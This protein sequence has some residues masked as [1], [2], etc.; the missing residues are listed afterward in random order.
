MAD[1]QEGVCAICGGINKDGRRLF[2]DHDHSTGKVRGLLCT[3]CNFGVGHFNDDVIL[4][5]KTVGYI[6][7][8]K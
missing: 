2:I 8:G 5:L 6:E 4:L 7:K 1:I 3:K